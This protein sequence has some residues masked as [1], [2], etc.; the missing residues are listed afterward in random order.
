MELSESETRALLINPQLLTAGRRFESLVERVERLRSVQ[1]ESLRQSEHLF[2][3]LLQ[4]A[5]SP[6]G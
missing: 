1:R 3:S 6:G 4:K 5:F 2:H